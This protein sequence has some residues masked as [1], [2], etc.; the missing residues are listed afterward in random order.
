[1]IGQRYSRIVRLPDIGEANFERISQ[2]RVALVGCGTLGGV[3]GINLVRLGVGSLRLID[4]D[5]AE[6]HNL[7]AQIFF[8]E[9]DVRQILPKAIAAQR[10][11]EAINSACRIEARVNDLTGN[12]AES[13]LG[14]VDLILDGT[15][16]FEARF[17]INDAALKLGIPWIYC[18]AVGYGGTTLAVVPGKTACLRCLMDSPPD[19]IEEPTCETAG[20]WPPAAQSAAAVALTEA[21]RILTGRAPSGKLWELDFEAL[22]WRGI[23]APRRKDCPACVRGEF[24][25]LR[26][27][28]GLQAVKM[29]GRDMVHLHPAQARPV[30]LIALAKRLKPFG[31]ISMNEFLLRLRTPEAEIFLFGDGRAFVKGVSDPARARALFHRYIGP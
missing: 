7:S 9:E 24:S 5:I 13:L 3:L 19:S 11:L 4:R 10:H 23:P 26:G 1:M 29:C 17:I 27:D 12:S 15:D 8:D 31:E 30:D 20:V 22:Q 21:S 16:N 14:G 2:A 18:G 6:D 25:H 28:L